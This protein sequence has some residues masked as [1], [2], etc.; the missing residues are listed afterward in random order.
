[1][2]GVMTENPPPDRDLGA[3]PVGYSSIRASL[4]TRL[5]NRVSTEIDPD[6]LTATPTRPLVYVLSCI[7][8]T[9]IR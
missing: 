3:Y 6:R 7:E 8:A 4:T 5:P 1:M 2:G 9:S